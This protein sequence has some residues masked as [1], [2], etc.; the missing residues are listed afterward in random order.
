MQPGK[1][2][3]LCLGD[4]FLCPKQRKKCLDH[5]INNPYDFIVVT[6]PCTM[7]SMLQYLGLGKSRESCMNAPEFQ[8]RYHEACVLLN[9]A[10][11]ICNIQSRR[12]RYFLFEQPWNAVSWNEA[13]VRKLLNAPA[14]HL[15]RTDQCMFGQKDLANNPIRKRTGFPY[16][17]C[18]RSSSFEKNMQRSSQ[19]S[20]V[21]RCLSG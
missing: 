4:Q 2:F 11:L 13:C 20:A 15:V 8:R 1:A 19:T 18:I 14:T 3:D 10:V 21:C 6:P 5:V 12:D 17:P 16:Q 7:F 9:F